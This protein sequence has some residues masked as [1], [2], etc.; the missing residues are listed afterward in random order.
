[1]GQTHRTGDRSVAK[2][3]ARLTE[4]DYRVS[5]PF[6]TDSPYDLV[7]DDGEKLWRAQVK[8]ARTRNGAVVFNC[9]SVDV[10]NRKMRLYDGKVDV[11]LAYSPETDRVYWVPFEDGTKSTMTLRVQP[12]ANNQSLGVRWAKDYEL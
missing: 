1:M 7:V 12:S 11:F 6:S 2:V 9:Y 10:Q 5:L 8:T 3:I 4:L